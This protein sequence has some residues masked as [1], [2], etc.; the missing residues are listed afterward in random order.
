MSGSTDTSGT[1]PEPSPPRSPTSQSE[2]EDFV[3]ARSTALYASAYL[4]TGDRGFAEDLVQDALARTWRAWKRLHLTANAEAYTRRTMYHLHVSSWRRT[5]V[6][7]IATEHLPERP[8]GEPDT[9]LRVAVHAA[10]LSLPAKQR[11]AI[12]LRYFEDQTE[13][14]AA[15]ILDCPVT[16]V[17]ARVQRGLRRLRTR[18]PELVLGDPGTPVSRWE[19]EFQHVR[20]EANA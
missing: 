14:A 1:P 6:A 8:G 10:L 3:K 7:E 17:R 11:A 18:F 19:M 12:V 2:F 9:A 5:K 4:L 13:T 16:T 15:A 20:G